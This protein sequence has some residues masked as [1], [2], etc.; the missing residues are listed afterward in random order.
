MSKTCLT[1]LCMVIW[2]HESL[3]LNLVIVG[4]K[5]AYANI[6]PKFCCSTLNFLEVGNSYGNLDTSTM[7]VLNNPAR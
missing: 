5:H 7:M 2:L 4:S 6:I 3:N 1:H